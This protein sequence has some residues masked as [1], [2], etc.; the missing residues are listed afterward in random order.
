MVMV[1][2][3]G[4]DHQTVMVLHLTNILEEV[5]VNHVVL[6]KII[7]PE[8]EAAEEVEAAEWE[9]DHLVHPAAAGAVVTVK[10][11]N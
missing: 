10:T 9:E 2:Q 7:I 1:L 4:M 11:G 3:V 6:M 5:A 8:E